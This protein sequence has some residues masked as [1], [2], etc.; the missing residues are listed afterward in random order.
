MLKTEQHGS[1]KKM[2]IPGV[3]SILLIEQSFPR[4]ITTQLIDVGTVSFDSKSFKKKIRKWP[5]KRGKQIHS[6]FSQ[7][8]CPEHT[9]LSDGEQV[10]FVAA[11]FPK[12][13][14]QM[15]RKYNHRLT[16]KNQQ[17][18]LE[19]HQKNWEFNCNSH[20]EV[21]RSLKQKQVK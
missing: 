6:W 18:C 13:H 3:V 9:G 14:T 17:F 5:V 21:L 7:S 1:K 8:P 20:L 19:V 2:D 12:Y 11:I 16:E 4:Y 15:T 10:E